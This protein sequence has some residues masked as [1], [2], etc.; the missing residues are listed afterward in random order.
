V[1]AVDLSQKFTSGKFPAPGD[2]DGFLQPQCTKL[3]GAYAG[4]TDVITSKNLV[5][6]W[7]NVTQQSW[8]A[9]TRRVACNLAAVLPDKSGYAPITGSVKGPV[10]VGN[11]PAAPAQPEVPPG[12]PAPGAGGD[13]S[14]SD[15]PAS[16]APPQQQ[17]S[18]APVPLPANPLPALGG[19][20]GNQG[21][22]PPAGPLG[23]G[24]KPPANPLGGADKP[25]TNPLGNEPALTKPA[26]AR[27]STPG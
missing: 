27:N 5:V 25:P 4:S 13:D 19:G 22:K 6:I 26:E 11:K 21:G 24:D 10:Q 23:G 15:G 16:Q 2:Q 12:A 8:A 17:P 14:D 7:N 20:N 3:A 18:I 1:G 9:G